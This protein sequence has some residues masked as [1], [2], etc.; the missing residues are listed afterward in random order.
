[1]KC[2]PGVMR[3]RYASYVVVL[4]FKAPNLRHSFFDPEDLR[5]YLPIR[6]L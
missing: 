3:E 2:R 6:L 5:V 4:S 1:M